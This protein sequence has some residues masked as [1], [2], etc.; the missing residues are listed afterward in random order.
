MI[1][2][3]IVN[4]I[5]CD[6]KNVLRRGVFNLAKRAAN[7]R[8]MGDFA[9]LMKNK[10]FY[11]FLASAL[12]GVAAT[13]FSS[14]SRVL[15]QTE[16]A[17]APEY[18]LND[19][20]TVFEQYSGEATS[21]VVPEGVKTIKKSA[22]LNCQSLESIVLPESLDT[23]EDSAFAGCS[24]L[25]SISVPKNVVSIGRFAFS[26][27]DAF[28]S[29]DVAED[30]PN[31]RSIDGVLFSKDGKRLIK[32]PGGRVLDVYFLPDGVETIEA[33]A[34]DSCYRINAVVVSNGVT[35]IESGAFRDA[36]LRTIALP[37][38]VED[39][40]GAGFESCHNQR[41][42]Y[43]A[44]KNKVYSSKNGVLLSKYGTTLIKVPAGRDDE[45]FAIPDGVATID[46]RAFLNCSR[47]NT[48][49]INAE[50]DNIN[51]N[52]FGSCAA[53]AFE[54]V[55][56]QTRYKT[57]DGV[58]FSADGTILLRYPQ[59]REQE[60]YV[61]PR[62]VKEIANNAFT[63]CQSLKKIELPE[64]VEK[65][66]SGAF[67]YCDALSSVVVPKSVATLGDDC[68]PAWD[69]LTVRG[70]KDSAVAR[71]ADGRKF[72]FKPIDET[73]DDTTLTYDLNED[74][75]MFVRYFGKGEKL[76]IPDGVNW[77]NSGAFD[78]RA[79]EKVIDLNV[80]RKTFAERV[81]ERGF[82]LKTIVIPTSVV[83]ADRVEFW[84]CYSLE[85]IDV[86]EKNLALRSIDGV[87]Y[88]KDET[89]LK[90][91]PSRI[92]KEEFVVPENVQVVE[93]Y[94]FAGC[95]SLK[96]I[97]LPKRLSAIGGG[98]F[99]GCSSLTSIV[100]PDGVKEIGINAFEDCS[101]LTSIVIPA[102][103][104]KIDGN[105][106]YPTNKL[107]ICASKGS[108]AEE[109]AKKMKIKFESLD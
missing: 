36:G 65:I 3:T 11:C 28:V 72:V 98:T 4:T 93:S 103:V 108:Y 31:Y 77:L 1:R 35:S 96:S 39:I 53:S 88:S 81:R 26:R 89:V 71:Y 33:Y 67:A 46:N 68:F 34:F 87:L 20:G 45:R 12:L 76:I 70:Y 38:S 83:K 92:K 41:S 7:L 61:V 49:V 2:A 75:S 14:D 40:G 95:S 69:K 97:V 29:I 101:S 54:A 90:C 51:H 48:V 85:S 44:E 6:D 19:D 18:Q 63:Y 52:T 100:V 102:S 23:I 47:L 25:K 56:T 73:V 50:V 10:R 43:V 99:A 107:T 58:L 9:M 109:F 17:Q 80:F 27:G 94:A 5:V 78:P 105:A 8:N 104:E 21:F 55:T 30:N 86:D 66:G 91:V 84:R 74:G 42:I 22:F 79:G 13:L 59:K 37:E 106:F 57:V 60:N 64:G 82:A 16:D 62:G 32:C 24:A 15:A